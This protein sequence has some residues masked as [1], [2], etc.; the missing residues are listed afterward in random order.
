VGQELQQD[1]IENE[2]T[3]TMKLLKV[4]VRDLMTDNFSRAKQSSLSSFKPTISGCLCSYLASSV[5]DLDF[6]IAR[7][8]SDIFSTSKPFEVPMMSSDV[9]HFSCKNP[10]PKENPPNSKQ[11]I[12]P[13]DQFQSEKEGK[14][15]QVNPECKIKIEQILVIDLTENNI[16]E[17]RKDLTHLNVT[18][19]AS[20][21]Q[22]QN[23][24]RKNK[25]LQSS[26][27]YI[28]HILEIKNENKFIEDTVKK[29]TVLI[30]TTTDKIS[31][32]DN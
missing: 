29:A 23:K 31:N 2:K 26:E 12:R 16:D 20:N 15:A 21:D 25:D 22:S 19:Q 5:F 8:H 32:T 13:T 11:T 14:P 27:E 6:H 24:T 4:H 1:T 17:N 7:D 9:D 28:E 30:S 3:K 10:K 18:T